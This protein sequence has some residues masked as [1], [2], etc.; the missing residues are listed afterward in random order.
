MLTYKEEDG[1]SQPEETT[2]LSEEAQPPPSAE[3]EN[4]SV[5]TAEPSTSAPPP[6]NLDM[7]DLLVSPLIWY[8]V[9]LN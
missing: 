9:M 4:V 3:V 2:E 7:D 1:P 8:F 6:T 5:S